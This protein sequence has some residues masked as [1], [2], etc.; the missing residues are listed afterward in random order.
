MERLHSGCGFIDVRPGSGAIVLSILCCYQ[1]LSVVGG[2]VLNS[3]LVLAAMALA[4]LSIGYN[5]VKHQ[6][7]K[8]VSNLHSMLS[9]PLALPHR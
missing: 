5:T 3:S 4:A 6:L 7:T 8:G 9:V 2:T 1:C